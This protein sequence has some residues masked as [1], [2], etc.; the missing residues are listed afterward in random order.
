PAHYRY[1]PAF[2]HREKKAQKSPAGDSQ[3]AVGGNQSGYQ[4][5]GHKHFQQPG[6]YGTQHD[7]RQCLIEDADKRAD[8]FKKLA[9][10][11]VI[12]SRGWNVPRD[13]SEKVDGER[14]RM[15]PTGTRFH[16][17]P[18]VPTPTLLMPAWAL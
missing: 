18:F 9:A 11:H 2:A 3:Y 5:L 15:L 7:K 17:G 16:S 10:F 14:G 12:P 1:D 4:A 8:Q 6:N 13:A